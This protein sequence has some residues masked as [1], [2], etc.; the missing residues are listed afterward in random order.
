MGQDAYFDITSIPSPGCQLSNYPGID[1]SDGTALNWTDKI[2]VV[3]GVD[4]YTLEFKYAENRWV[5]EK[6]P[7]NL[8]LRMQPLGDAS[9]Y[10][11]V[12]LTV[13]FHRDCTS[14]TSPITTELLAP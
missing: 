10:R 14:Q 12:Q 2:T 5:E 8:I 1:K 3:K 6:N 13:H 9:G 7:V 11:S 4:K